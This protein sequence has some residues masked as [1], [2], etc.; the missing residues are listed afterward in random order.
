MT[1]RTLALSIPADDTND[2]KNG[3]GKGKD[4]PLQLQDILVDYFYNS[5]ITGVRRQV[6]HADDNDQHSPMT[7]NNI[8]ENVVASPSMANYFNR[9]STEE[10]EQQQQKDEK[11]TLKTLLKEAQ[12]NYINSSSDNNTDSE[13][14]VQVEEV[15]EEITV[16]AWQVLEL[17]PFYSATNEQGDAIKTQ[18]DSSFP[19]THMVLPIVLK[20]Y[21]YNNQGGST[22]IKRRVEIPVTIDFN[23]FVNLNVDNPLCPTCG[24]LIDWTLHFKSAVC[25]LGDSPN[26]GHYISYARVDNNNHLKDKEDDDEEE[27][28]WLK[29]DDM[30]HNSRVTYIKDNN[31]AEEIYTDLA[32]NAYIVFYE[33]DK[34]CHHGRNS[35]VYSDITDEEEIEMREDIK[36]SGSISTHETDSEEQVCNYGGSFDDHEKKVTKSKSKSSS[37][38][39]KEHKHHHHHH[40]RYHLKDQCKLM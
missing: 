31:N 20:R 4:A 6:D 7:T 18:M 32:E 34:T 35:S 38:N 19:D 30:D 26:S 24:H 16:T 39:K 14:Q 11:Y 36:S 37:S 22:K 3:A 1:D 40:H 10:E 8:S 23:K 21:K 28:Y 5:I 17:L 15:E 29:L 25:H 2:V 27:P 9:Q 13:D 12:Q 33:L